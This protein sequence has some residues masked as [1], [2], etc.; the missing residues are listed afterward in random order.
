M[1]TYRMSHVGTCPRAL[2]A[3][4]LGLTK[5]AQPE[6]L[7]TAAN[8]GKRH[9]DWIVEDLNSQGLL[10]GNRQLEI[11]LKLTDNIELL[12]H[13]DGML[14]DNRLLEVK[15]MSQY[16][17]DRWMRGRFDEFPTY[18]VQLSCYMTALRLNK[19]LYIVKNRSSG[20]IDRQEI[21]G[22]P[23]DMTELVQDLEEVERA[24]SQ[25]KLV[26][27]QYDPTTTK[28]KRCVYKA[29]CLQ[30]QH[31]EE[32]DLPRLM[33]AVKSYREGTRLEKQ[34]KVLVDSAKET[35]L[36]HIL[37]INKD[38]WLFEHLSMTLISK[39]G[40]HYDKAML[41]QYLT[42]EQL[43]QCYIPNKGTPYI[44][45]YDQLKEVEDNEAN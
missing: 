43:E 7:E 30:M 40:Y 37:A 34:G 12:G 13:I 22:T 4:R 2:S 29:H 15:T 25:G 23:I 1:I 38:K 24:V 9:E 14:S 26:D 44:K 5:E 21:H 36:E 42:E 11:K 35:F 17:F 3:E 10:V 45:V 31:V 27:R 32:K 33:E 39:F 16:E 20:Y 28:C 19:A 8:E 6:Y 41:K 18:A